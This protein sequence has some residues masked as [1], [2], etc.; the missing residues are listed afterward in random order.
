MPVGAEVPKTLFLVG[1]TVA[2]GLMGAEAI[3]RAFTA[4]AALD[5]GWALVK[6]LCGTAVTPPGT[7]R[8]TY[9]MFALLLLLTL[10]SV[11]T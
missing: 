5:T 7:V 1:A 6:A 10:L 4:T 3:S 2:L 9:L 8:L 11:V